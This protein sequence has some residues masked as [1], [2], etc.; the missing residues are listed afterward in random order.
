MVLHGRVG[1]NLDFFATPALTA[2][3]RPFDLDRA[4]A[5]HHLTR[6]PAIED[7]SG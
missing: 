2:Q 4:I 3:T 7:H 1:G 5:E 6:L